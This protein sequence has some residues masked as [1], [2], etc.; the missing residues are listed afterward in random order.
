MIY[1]NLNHYSE[2]QKKTKSQPGL[3]IS[4]EGL[5]AETIHTNKYLKTI[6]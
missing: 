3:S 1:N 4:H 5:N 6:L 2:E